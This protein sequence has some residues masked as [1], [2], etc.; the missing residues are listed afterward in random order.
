MA[1][2]ASEGAP[3]CHHESITVRNDANSDSRREMATCSPLPL[4]SARSLSS[5][6][7]ELQVLRPLLPVW[8]RSEAGQ[9]ALGQPALPPPGLPPLRGSASLLRSER[10]H[11]RV[12]QPS[13][14]Y[15]VRQRST[16]E[17]TPL[18]ALKTTSRAI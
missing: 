4:A 18:D 13:C 16:N 17:S 7:H 5:P 3:A 2:A 10:T 15:E 8:G 6:M 1:Q 14:C 9:F 12:R 11:R